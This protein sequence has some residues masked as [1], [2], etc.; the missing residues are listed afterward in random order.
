MI[1]QANRRLHSV[2]M[3]IADNLVRHCSYYRGK[4]EVD[5]S[6]G[7]YERAIRVKT[8]R[9]SIRLAF[10][11]LAG[12]Q[13]MRHPCFRKADSFWSSSASFIIRHPCH[14]SC[15][16]WRPSYH[17]CLVTHAIGKRRSWHRL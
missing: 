15:P 3:R 9:R 8:A 2:L 12:D 1:R 4:A 10:A 5:R 6:R 13:S 16:I 14:T 7:L 11:C 17:R